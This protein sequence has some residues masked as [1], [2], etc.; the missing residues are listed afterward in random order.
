MEAGGSP[1]NPRQVSD[2]APTGGHQLPSGSWPARL[3]TRSRWV[4]DASE[5]RCGGGFESEM[6]I[7][8]AEGFTS[9]LAHTGTGD[10]KSQLQLPAGGAE[11]WGTEYR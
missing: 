5:M 11:S 4:L 1:L 3:S 2:N 8:P 9:A 7:C 6:L 10:L